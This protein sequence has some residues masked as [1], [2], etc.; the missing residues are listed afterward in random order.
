MWF[1]WNLLYSKTFW[2]EC[3]RKD[4][5]TP[6]GVHPFE[7]IGSKVEKIAIFSN[8]NFFFRSLIRDVCN[9]TYLSY[10][11]NITI[12]WFRSGV[13]FLRGSKLCFRLAVITKNMNFFYLFLFEWLLKENLILTPSG[14]LPRCEIKI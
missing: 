4:I 14:T 3:S 2:V 1:F 13:R 5:F 11:P 6:I 9:I 10:V 7:K 8:N 12:F